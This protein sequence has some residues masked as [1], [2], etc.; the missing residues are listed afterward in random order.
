MILYKVLEHTN[1][2]DL[3]YTEIVPKYCWE[4]VFENWRRRDYCWTLFTVHTNS[5]IPGNQKTRKSTSN[6][7]Q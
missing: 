5:Y 4:I 3:L 6:S 1:F 2:V 7:G